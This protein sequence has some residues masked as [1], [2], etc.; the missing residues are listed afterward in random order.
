MPK[1]KTPAKKVAK[2]DNMKMEKK[3]HKG[4]KGKCKTCG[5]C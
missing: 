2:M 3:E 5:K 4:M 1:A